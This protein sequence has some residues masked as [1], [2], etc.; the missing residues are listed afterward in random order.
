MLEHGG[1]LHDAVRLFGRPRADW[2]DLST[3][4][5]PRPYPAPALEASIWHRLPEPDAELAAAAQAFYG[6]PQMLPVAG[7]QA[8][9]QALPILRPPSRSR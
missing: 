7:S 9:I 3:G 2:L 1:N 4:I 8:A 5:N 6:A